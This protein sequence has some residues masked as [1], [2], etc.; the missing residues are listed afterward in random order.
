[1]FVVINIIGT[2][3]RGK[4]AEITGLILHRIIRICG[5]KNKAIV[6]DFN[7]NKVKVTAVQRR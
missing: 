5:E 1:M 6:R 4:N 3:K 2:N 7:S